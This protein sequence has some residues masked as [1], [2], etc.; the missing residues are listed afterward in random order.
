MAG[1]RSKGPSGRRG[2]LVEKSG[3]GSPHLLQ[4][5]VLQVVHVYKGDG[6]AALE[7]FHPRKE[8]DLRDKCKVQRNVSALPW[9]EENSS[10]LP[11]DYIL[12]H[13]RQEPTRPFLPFH[14]C[15]P[16]FLLCPAI[17]SL[18]SFGLPPPKVHPSPHLCP[19]CLQCSKQQQ[20]D[21]VENLLGQE[22]GLVWILTSR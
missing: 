17:S 11:G 19:G 16:C 3:E 6:V 4:Q 10:E 12:L 14:P 22:V 18:P 21:F 20:R 1:G 13:E 8:Q 9:R 2:E 7:D 15:F 5:L